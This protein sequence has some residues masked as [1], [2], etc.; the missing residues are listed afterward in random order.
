MLDDP[1][2]I[3]GS[4]KEHNLVFNKNFKNNHPAA[5]KIATRIAND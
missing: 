5:Y 2:K 1:D 4:G 3:Y